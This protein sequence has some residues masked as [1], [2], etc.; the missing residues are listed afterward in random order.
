MKKTCTGLGPADASNANLNKTILGE[1]KQTCVVLILR[2]FSACY[3]NKQ[4]QKNTYHIVTR[5]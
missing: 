3:Q 4:R 1:M 2:T 5:R